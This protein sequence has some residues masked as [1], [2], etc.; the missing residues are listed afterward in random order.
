M[1]TETQQP[2]E[3]DKMSILP[4]DDAI[5]RFKANEERIDIFVNDPLSTGYYTTNEQTPRQVKTLPELADEIAESVSL[6]ADL[7][8]DA[9]GKGDALIA[10]K[11]PFT[12]AVSTT[13]QLKN[14]EILN[15]VID[16]GCDNT[17]ATNTTAKLLAF[18]NACIDNNKQGKIPAG[19]YLVTTGILVFDNNFTDK[20]FPIIYTDG[21]YSTIFK[22]DSATATNAPIIA[23]KNGTANS[24]AGKYWRGGYHGGITFLDDTGASASNRH[25][26]SIAGTWNLKLGHI[27]GKTLRGS[28]INLPQNL[29]EGAN[30]DP[31]ASSFTQVDAVESLQ[32]ARY[33]IEN[34]N[35]LGMDSWT[36]QNVIGIENTLGVWYGIGSGCKC[37]TLTAGSCQGWVFDDGTADG[38]FSVQR[39]WF[40]VAELDNC[41]YGIKLNKSSYTK[42]EQFRFVHRYN[43]T[44]VK[45]WPLKAVD[46]CSGSSPNVNNCEFNIFH[47]FES[48]GL[49]ANVGVVVDGNN[50]GNLNFCKFDM[51]YV[52]N[53]SLG[54]TDDKLFSNIRISTV[55][56]FLKNT[57]KLLDTTDKCIIVANGSASTSINNTGF[58][59]ASSKIQYASQL[60]PPY[61]NMWLQDTST[62]T[63]PRTGL[64]KASIKFSIAATIGTRVRIG[65]YDGSNTRG[66]T[67][68]YQITA[69]K[70]EYNCES[71]L[72][73][74]KGQT[75]IPIADQN[76]AGP[77]NVTIDY[78]ND[79]CQFSIMEL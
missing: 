64:Y 8:S 52:D 23:I 67:T 16:F 35:R 3:R 69:G 59:S 9:P 33:T 63:A 58:L 28:V 27:K 57:R 38:S 13:Q 30:P 7:A 61:T 1:K 78:Y 42:F 46:L 41:Q 11:Q 70:Q 51:T 19:T 77:I 14:T 48:G 40:G 34:S 26:L 10:V 4:T 39:N 73:L 12:G 62:F 66:V 53:G 71:I 68:D 60:M 79:E 43:P 72:Y 37:Y 29:Y 17:G 18:Y 25:G 74:T 31:Y 22:V 5:T 76:T 65:Y 6:R 44:P 15:A 32:C 56:L 21:H 55:N 54:I 49:L 50:S 36:I 75:I 2:N 24:A 45:Y 47:R 20:A